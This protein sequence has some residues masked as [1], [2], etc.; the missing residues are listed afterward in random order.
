MRPEQA[1]AKLVALEG[2]ARDGP[3]HDLAVG[4]AVRGDELVVGDWNDTAHQQSS[5]ELRLGEPSVEER[6]VLVVIG[7]EQLPVERVV[8]AFQDRRSP[9]TPRGFLNQAT[10]ATK[11]EP[12]VSLAVSNCC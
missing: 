5:S 3:R 12:S 7:P 9:A 4:A 10:T 2:R 1:E 6:G 11:R 8:V